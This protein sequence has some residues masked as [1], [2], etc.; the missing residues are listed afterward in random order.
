MTELIRQCDLLVQLPNRRSKCQWEPLQ[1]DR[2]NHQKEQPQPEHRHRD[3]Q[4]GEPL[5]RLVETA[6]AIHSC[7]HT[8]RETDHAPQHPCR[9]H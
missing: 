8:K 5:N 1:L 2:E 9:Q 3:A 7:K 6:A 4:Q